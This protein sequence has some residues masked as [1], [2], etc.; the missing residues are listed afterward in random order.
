[1][2]G[3]ETGGALM[4]TPVPLTANDVL[5]LRD[6]DNIEKLPD[7]T[8]TEIL[9]KGKSSVFVKVI[10]VAQVLW[11]T[12]QIIVRSVRGLHISQLELVVT[13]F[14]ACAVITYS[15]L[16][17]KPQGV[18][19]PARPI[20]CKP[21]S[22][23]QAIRSDRGWYLRVLFI[24]GTTRTA[25]SNTSRTRIPNDYTDGKSKNPIVYVGGII[26]G[27]VVFGSVHVAGW[28]FDFPTPVEQKLW[29]ISSLAIAFLLP[30]IFLPVLL[31]LSGFASFLN[32]APWS[33]AVQLWGLILG[34]LYVA[35]RLYLLVEIFR[36]LVFLPPGAYVST[37]TSNIPHIS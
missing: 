5:W 33:K 7:I 29:R 11:I 31:I 28:N 3:V 23:Q 9:D 35:S 2:V 22:I 6:S 13:A 1:M 12:I 36:T 32:R 37:W 10:A 18:Q 20:I 30:V 4:P 34:V 27:G 21:G 16:I 19:V 24:P 26:L 14:S 17:W 8:A 15:F 25:Y